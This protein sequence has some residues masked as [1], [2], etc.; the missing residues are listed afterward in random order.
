MSVS[1]GE[2]LKTVFEVTLDDGTIA[3]NVW[4]HIASFI[5]PEGDQDVLDAIEVWTEGMYSNLSPQ[6]VSTMTQ[7]LCTVDK[8]EFN[9]LTD[10]WEVVEH[11]GTFT[12]TI[13]FNNADE[14]LP[15]Q[16]SPFITFN[17]T[18]PKSRGRKFLFPMGENTQAGTFIVA[19]TVANLVSFADDALDAIVVDVLSNLLLGIPRVG[20]DVFLEIFVAVVT[21]VLG[22]QR[23]RRPGVGV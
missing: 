13:G 5:S 16:S 2:I 12:P 19:G 17:T 18:R 7:N 15:N 9:D 20:L 8:I 10:I 3:Q 14:Q 23:R 1:N 4:Y 6:F 21:N 11:V 22:S